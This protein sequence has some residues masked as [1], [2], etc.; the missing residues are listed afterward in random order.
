M[1]EINIYT[2]IARRIARYQIAHGITQAEFSAL[3]GIYPRTLIELMKTGRCRQT[4][5]EKIEMIL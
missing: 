2:P 4:T 5:R 1:A 3:V